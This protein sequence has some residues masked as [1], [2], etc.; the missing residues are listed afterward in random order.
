MLCIVSL[1]LTSLMTGSLYLS[2]PHLFHS[3]P[4]PL[5]WKQVCS[6][7]LSV[8]FCFVMF[9]LFKICLFIY[10]FI[11]LF[12]AAATA[13]GS[14]QARG[15]MEPKLLAYTTGT[16][17]QD[18]SLKT[19][20]L[21]F[22][23][24]FLGPHLQHMEVPRLGVELE[25]PAYEMQDPSCDCDLHHSSWQCGSLT[26]WGRPGIESSPFCYRWAMTGTPAFTYEF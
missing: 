25:L 17:T 22:L 15:W 16:A 5:L 1:W 10:L 6:L 3:S 23:F 18:P 13:Y 12:R 9:V 21:F 20:F 11:L 4:H 14:S 7:Y 19:K 2:L 26:H 24:C 8:C